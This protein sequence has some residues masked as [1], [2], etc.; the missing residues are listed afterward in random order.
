M[1]KFVLLMFNDSLHEA[2]QLSIL[3]SSDVAF[4][5]FSRHATISWGKSVFFP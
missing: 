1:V 5:R 3:L 2:S 4:L